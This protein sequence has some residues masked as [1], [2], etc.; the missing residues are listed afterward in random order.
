[1]FIFSF[2]LFNCQVGS[3]SSLFNVYKDQCP[4]ENL[5]SLFNLKWN[6]LTSFDITVFQ[7]RNV[8]SLTFICEVRSYGQTEDLPVSCN[9]PTSTTTTTTTT[10]TTASTTTTVATTNVPNRRKRNVVQPTMSPP[11]KGTFY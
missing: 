9:T 3:G 11:N 4:D 7:I 2:S 10:T 1:M 8:F 5:A 6:D